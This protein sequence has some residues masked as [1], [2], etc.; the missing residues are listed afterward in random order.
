MFRQMVDSGCSAAVM[1]VSSHALVLERVHGVSFQVGVFTNLTPEHLDFHE[2]MGRYAEAKQKL[3][4]QLRP[5][6]VAVVNADDAAAAAMAA[7]L[8]MEKVYCCSINGTRLSCPPQNSFSAEVKGMGVEGSRVL[9]GFPDGS[10]Q[11]TIGLPGIFNV[12]NVLEACAAG[13][14]MGLDPSSVISGLESMDSVE[15]RMQRIW[16]T[17]RRRCAIVDYAHTPDALQKTLETLVQIKPGN[18]RLLV[19]FGCGG[20]RDRLKRPEMGRIASEYADIV[21][22][23]S[24]NPRDEDPEKIL[25]EI[26]QGMPGK[27]FRRISDRAEAIRTAVSELD[28]GD[29]LLVA[30]KGH[31]KY[32]EIKGTKHFFS[33]QEILRQCLQV[34]EVI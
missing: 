7:K 32:Q 8:P 4:G 27:R 1:E 14:A 11:M 15:G 20:N 31:E 9:I 29:L 16:D 17:G 19:V 30:G 26:E 2:T 12:M 22:I 13:V 10:R 23:T 21:I 24:D 3:F 34:K 6:G 18:S 33:D 25:D 5:D 28:E